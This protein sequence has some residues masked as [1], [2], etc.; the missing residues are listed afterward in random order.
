MR[1]AGG[2]RSANADMSS[3]KVCERHTRRKPKVSCAT[4]IGAG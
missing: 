3:D 1:N 2:I 4:L